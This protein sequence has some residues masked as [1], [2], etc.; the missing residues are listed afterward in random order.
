MTF[1][2]SSWK[3]K[4]NVGPTPTSSQARVACLACAEKQLTAECKAAWMPPALLAGAPGPKG[5]GWLTG[6]SFLPISESVRGQHSGEG[7]EGDQA[8]EVDGAGS[9]VVEND[10]AI[11][12]GDDDAAEG[13]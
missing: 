7:E 4:R 3:W 2:Q 10:A 8:P 1:S 6:R 12:G 13:Y 9:V 11:A 5:R